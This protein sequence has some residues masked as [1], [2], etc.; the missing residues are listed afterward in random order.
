MTQSMRLTL[1]G[2]CT[3]LLTTVLSSCS[4][5]GNNAP[6]KTELL[7]KQMWKIE[8]SGL[9]ADK[10]GTIDLL[11]T[12]EACELDNTFLFKPDGSGV[13]DEGATKCSVTDPQSSEFTWIFKNNETILSGIIPALGFSGDA[14]ISALN[15]STLEVYQDITIAGTPVR[16]IIRLKH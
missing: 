5:E 2:L 12:W 9:D 14:N 8:K 6:T 4:K 3:I 13:F 1:F 11:D 16:Y 15:D 10:N 7:T